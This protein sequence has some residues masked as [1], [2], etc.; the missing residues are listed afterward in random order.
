[1]K[2]KKWL[3]NFTRK[4]FTTVISEK[5][6]SVWICQEIVSL[7]DSHH[8]RISKQ[9]LTAFILNINSTNNFWSTRFP[10]RDQTGKYRAESSLMSERRQVSDTPNSESKK[11]APN[12]CA[13]NAFQT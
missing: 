8:L 13:D 5:I 7:M 9:N 1:M 2:W 3:K 12:F 4:N 10:T 6:L 11:E